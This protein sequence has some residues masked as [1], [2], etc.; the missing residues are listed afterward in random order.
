MSIKRNKRGTEDINV[1]SQGVLVSLRIRCYGA[2]S[3][4]P[5]SFYQD[6][7]KMPTDITRAV[8]DI[9]PLVGGVSKTALKELHEMRDEAKRYLYRY[10]LPHPVDGL[11]F[12]LKKDIPDVD[13]GL[14]RRQEAFLDKVDIFDAGYPNAVQDY[15]AKYPE[16][17]EA[18]KDRYPDPE[19]MQHRFSFEWSFRHF[20]V[21]DQALSVLP[22]EVYK[23]EL[24]KVRQDARRMRDTA[25][26]AI[27]QE[28]LKRIDSLKDQCQTGTINTGTVD[29]LKT[30]LDKFVD[31]WDDYLGHAQ[32]AEM[33]EEVKEHLDGIGAEE[34]RIDEGFRAL[35]GSKMEEVCQQFQNIADV[36]LHRRIDI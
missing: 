1:F 19:E 9:L 34:L 18:Y 25:V 30:F 31:G 20:V 26:S 24:E 3:R 10:S 27:G 12:I 11:V 2:R 32:L 5:E 21:P 35:V 17:Y 4:V 16:Q 29:A 8:Q 15:A 33:V 13:E 23:E 28:F 6:N 7:K 22:P 14:K 36:R